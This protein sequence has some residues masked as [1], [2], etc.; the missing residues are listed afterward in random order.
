MSILAAILKVI[1]IG[2]SPRREEYEPPARRVAPTIGEANAQHDYFVSCGIVNG[3]PGSLDDQDIYTAIAQIE[4][5]DLSSDE[6]YNRLD[7][8]TFAVWNNHADGMAAY[9]ALDAIS[10]AIE[11]L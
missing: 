8:L 9:E 4:N 11:K 6:K 5:S 7:P 2:P 1:F 3:T 10:K